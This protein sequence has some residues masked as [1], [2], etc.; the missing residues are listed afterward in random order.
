[1]TNFEKW[2]EKLTVE[3]AAFYIE[4]SRDGCHECL[5]EQFCK[6]IPFDKHEEYKTCRKVITVWLESDAAKKKE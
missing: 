3:K 5:I 6:T 2:R 1:M 4:K